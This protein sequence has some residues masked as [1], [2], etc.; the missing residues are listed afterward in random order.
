MMEYAGKVEDGVV[1][2]AIVGTAAWAME[3]LGG[4]WY[5]S[6]K[7]VP[8]PGLWDEQHGFR[9]MQPSPDCWWENDRW[10]CPEYEIEEES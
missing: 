2:D 4:V 9:P 10:M 5:N 3:N 7:K 1:V 8:V 6:D